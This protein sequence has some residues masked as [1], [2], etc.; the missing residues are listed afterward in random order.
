MCLDPASAT[1]LLAFGASGFNAYNAY[2]SNKTSEG[3]A[4]ANAQQVQQIGL[5]N[6]MSFRDQARRDIADQ[7]ARIGNSGTVL[8]TG[9]PLLLLAESAKNKEL[10]ALAIRE[11]AGAQAGAYRMQASA[12]NRAA[13][14]S[15]AGELLSGLSSA[16]GMG[17]LGELGKIGAKPATNVGN[18]Q[19]G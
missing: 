1:M 8:D 17:A 19:G 9:T 12:Y 13:P 3:I 5:R 7:V 6:E 2:S 10:D 15:A 16:S 4:N 14:M 18:W 11:N